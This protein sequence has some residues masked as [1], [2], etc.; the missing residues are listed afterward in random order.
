MLGQAMDGLSDIIKPFRVH[1]KRL[2][3]GRPWFSSLLDCYAVI[4]FSVADAT[5]K[6]GR[7]AA[8]R[9]GC[10]YCCYHK[11][12]LSTAELMGLKLYAG[13]VLDAETK[14]FLAENLKKGGDL[15]LFN[16]DGVCT[17]YPVRPIACRRYVVLGESCLKEELPVVTRPQDA[18]KPSG[19]LFA[20]AAELTLPFYDVM[21]IPRMQG[22]SPLDFYKR[23]NVFLSSVYSAV[24]E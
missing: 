12:P 7:D 14:N 16:R 17:V 20:L 2:E 1:I 6:S 21:R 8:C 11:I 18:L 9:K 22:E 5:A 24:L 13:H 19:R 10:N 4:D 23:Q 3:Q 15:C